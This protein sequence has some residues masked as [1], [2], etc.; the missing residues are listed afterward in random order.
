MLTTFR[1]RMYRILRE[2]DPVGL[3]QRRARAFQH[4]GQ[5]ILPGPNDA[6]SLD[7]YC[8]LEH[9]GIQ[10]YAA[11][12]VY[13]RFVV[14]YYVGISGRT[15][16]SVLGQY[17]STVAT[18]K[19]VPRIVRTDRGTET[20]MTADAHYQIS[21]EIRQGPLEFRDTFRFGTSKQNSTIERWWRQQSFGAILQWRD[22]FLQYNREEAYNADWLSD[23]TA[24]LAIYMPILR[25]AL[26]QFVHVWNNHRIRK[27]PRRPY[28]TPGIPFLLYHYPEH[29]GGVESGF[30]VPE[31]SP[32][33]QSIQNDLEDLDLDEYLP[34]NTLRWCGD[35]L[36]RRGFAREIDGSATNDSGERIHKLAFYALRDTARQYVL[37]G[38]QPPLEE[39]NKPWSAR[40]WSNNYVPPELIQRVFRNANEEL[41]ITHPM[42][43][44]EPE[45]YLN[46]GQAI[47]DG[48]IDPLLVEL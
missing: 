33:L 46:D 14:W 3:E 20:P 16:V 24:F 30:T 7:A 2:L 13:S 12:D 40:R 39:S 21:S 9:W 11:V 15:A 32:T 4:R 22:C 27:Q 26:S 10:I 1:N 38:T 45:P 34:P 42:D 5:V 18:K 19:I 43:P 41:V 29:T 47:D 28:L 44:I 31:D 37:R 17:I 36:E 48:T 8:K 35:E 25:N 6:W 23:R